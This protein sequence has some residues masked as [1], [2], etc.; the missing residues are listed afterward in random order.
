MKESVKL[1]QCAGSFWESGLLSGI[2]EALQAVLGA[3]T[4]TILNALCYV[5][6]HGAHACVYHSHSHAERETGRE[7]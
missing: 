7:I 4:S 3:A 1:S 6:M 5:V 2:C